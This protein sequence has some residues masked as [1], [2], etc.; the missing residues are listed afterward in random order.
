MTK[1]LNI[2]VRDQESSQSPTAA[3]REGPREA[4]AL[5]K[6]LEAPVAPVDVMIEESLA[7]R[8]S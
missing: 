7:G 6:G 4:V 5:L 2:L 3:R 1:R 8:Y